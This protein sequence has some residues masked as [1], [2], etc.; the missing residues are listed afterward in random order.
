MSVNIK[1]EEAERL[2]RALAS[3][4]GESLTGA[5]TTALRERLERVQQRSTEEIEA[6]AESIRKIAADSADRW[7]QPYRRVEHGDL[8]YDDHGLPK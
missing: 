8:L 4:T 2:A 3:V 7:A 6:R 5:V 1:S